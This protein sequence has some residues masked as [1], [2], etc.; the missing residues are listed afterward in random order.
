[1]TIDEFLGALANLR[2][3]Y[4]WYADDLGALRAFLPPPVSAEHS[5]MTALAYAQTG[6]EWDFAVDWEH[7]ALAIGLTL[8]AAMRLVSAEDGEATQL[9]L[10]R[11][12]REAVGLK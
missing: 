8:E 11:A 6:E 5:P 10:T 3:R 4:V 1:M 2:E 9:A 7:A 12:L